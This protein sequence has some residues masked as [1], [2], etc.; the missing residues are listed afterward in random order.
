MRLPAPVRA[1]TALARTPAVRAAAELVRAPAALTVP[2]D[3]LAG[4]VAAGRELGAAAVPL[5]ALSSVAL[6]WAGMALNDFADRETDADERPARPIPSGRVTPGAALALATGLTGAGLA[7]AGA[8]GGRRTLAVAVPLAGTVWAYDLVAKQH[9]LAG[10][11][12][13]AAARA[14]DVLMGAGYGRLRAAL[15][16]A[17][18]I[19]AHTLVVSVLSS[20]EV[21]GAEAPL[22][23][24]TLA[25]TGG[26]TALAAVPGPYRGGPRQAVRAAALGLYTAGFGG[27]QAT[28]GGRDPLRVR[29]A[30]AAGIAGLLPLQAA[31]AARAGAAPVAAGLLA[32]LP[33]TRRL[34][35]KVS[36]T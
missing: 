23:C 17:V 1:A 35:R 32:V 28:A 14:L 22:L 16:A 5:T 10:P 9:P 19:G 36:P 2:G 33:L 20:R 24:A 18:A 31:C 30:V 8:A 6:Y 15:P 12:T 25:A 26:V 21:E 34:F 11:A 3:S 4:A 27:A 29:R 13:M 7:L